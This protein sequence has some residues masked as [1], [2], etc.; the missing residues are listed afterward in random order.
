MDFC[1]PAE[2]LGVFAWQ[3]L[4]ATPNSLGHLWRS[5]NIGLGKS[6]FLS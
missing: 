5:P 6:H 2:C 3:H 4:S 1:P